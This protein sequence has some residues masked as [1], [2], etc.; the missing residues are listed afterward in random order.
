MINNPNSKKKELLQD[1]WQKKI[2]SSISQFLDDKC[3]LLNTFGL[4]IY[5]QQKAPSSQFWVIVGGQQI[6]EVKKWNLSFKSYL[7]CAENRCFIFFKLRCDF[8]NNHQD[9]ILWS[10]TAP[11][12]SFINR[13]TGFIYEASGVFLEAGDYLAMQFKKVIKYFIK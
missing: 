13:E 9:L 11:T 7:Y 8:S 12:S 10:I 2:Y 6:N 3:I 1:K 5:L 4:Y